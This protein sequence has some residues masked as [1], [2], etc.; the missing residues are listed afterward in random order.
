MSLS[1]SKHHNRFKRTSLARELISSIFIQAR[2]IVGLSVGLATRRWAR[3]VA[4]LSNLKNDLALISLPEFEFGKLQPWTFITTKS[5]WPGSSA[6][7][8]ARIENSA[9]ESTNP[10]SLGAQ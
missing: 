7:E 6:P 2:E 4:D 5:C 1:E 8:F 9:V 10:C 3:S